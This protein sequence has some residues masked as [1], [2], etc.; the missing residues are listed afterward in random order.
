MCL[1]RNLR[2][3]FRS[4]RGFLHLGEWKRDTK[5]GERTFLNKRAPADPLQTRRP[6]TKEKQRH[7]AERLKWDQRVFQQIARDLEDFC[8]PVSRDIALRSFFLWYSGRLPNTAVFVWL[9]RALKKRIIYLN[10]ILVWRS[11]LYARLYC[12]SMCVRVCVCQCVCACVRVCVCVCVSVCVCV[13]A[14]EFF[15]SIICIP[16]YLCHL[17]ALFLNLIRVTY[18]TYVHH[19]NI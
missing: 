11:P 15:L 10:F 19:F 16:F 17:F 18:I 5:R 13:C 14:F 8:L 7:K 1:K 9:I 12:L 3:L 2:D 4:V 6:G